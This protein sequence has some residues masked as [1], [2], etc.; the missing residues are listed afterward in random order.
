MHRSIIPSHFRPETGFIYVMRIVF[1]LTILL[2]LKSILSYF[3]TIT[4]QQL[5]HVCFLFQL[6]V[7]LCGAI[8]VPRMATKPCLKIS[9]SNMAARRN[10]RRIRSLPCQTARSV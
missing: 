4:M 8:R 10:W 7:G 3:V 1:R 2:T 6:K 9:H 5:Y